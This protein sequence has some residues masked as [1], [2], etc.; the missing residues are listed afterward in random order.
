MLNEFTSSALFDLRGRIALVTGGGRGIGF[1]IAR[2]LAGA[3]AHVVINGRDKAKLADVVEQW[4]SE[5]LNADC[6]AFD[7]TDPEAA[8]VGVNKIEAEVGAIGILVNNA[9]IQHRQPLE[10]FAVADWDRIVQ[11]NLSSAFYVAKPV[12]QAMIPRGRGSIINICSVQ[13]ELGR[14]SIAPYA[15]TKGGLKMLTKGMAIDWG[16]YGI[17]ANAVGPGYFRTDLNQALV[18]DEQFSA[19]L[20]NRTPL[21]RWGKVD[22]LVGA[23]IFLASEASSFV[24]GQVIYVDGGVTSAL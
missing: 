23:A 9:G 2:G 3:G 8:R 6:M 14:P 12:A 16:K 20:V 19:W 7:V 4:R 17:R 24:T 15:A 22:E 13:S 5:G 18:Q 10:Q 11:T 1:A 21:R